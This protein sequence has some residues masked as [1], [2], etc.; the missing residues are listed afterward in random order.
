MI[1]SG[2]GKSDEKP[3]IS[4]GYFEIPNQGR[5]GKLSRRTSLVSSS[6]ALFNISHP[7]CFILPAIVE[8]LVLDVPTH[9]NFED[10]SPDLFS[11]NC[12]SLVLVF[13]DLLLQ[14]DDTVLSLDF[15][16]T[17]DVPRWLMT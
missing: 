15:T 13:S 11:H 4:L 5:A 12:N 16:Q 14:L 2:R 9:L 3:Q 6:F 1:F 7:Q 17:P 8:V 10:C